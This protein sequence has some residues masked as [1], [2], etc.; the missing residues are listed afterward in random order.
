[1]ISI[2]HVMLFSALIFA[3]GLYGA[4][5]R[6]NAIGILMSIELILNAANI[7]LVAMARLWGDK[8]GIL[9]A[10]FVIGTAAAATIVGLAILIAVYRNA[11]TVYADRINLLRW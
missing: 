9:F 2:T 3:I 6:R 4:L 10:V 7:N 8:S 5:T 1:M 11:K